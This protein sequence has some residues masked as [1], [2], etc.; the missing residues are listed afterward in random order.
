MPLSQL[1]FKG[2][3]LIF[4]SQ[5][6]K[7]IPFEGWD[8][9]L[10]EKI[11]F[12]DEKGEEA[13]LASVDSTCIHIASWIE[14]EILASRSTIIFSKNGKLDYY[15]RFGPIIIPFSNQLIESMNIKLQK[16]LVIQD[17][18]IQSV[19]RE[20]IESAIQLSLSNILTNSYLLIDGSLTS[21]WFYKAEPNLNQII[22][23]ALKN[24]NKIVGISKTSS[25][26]SYKETFKNLVF[27][28]NTPC[29]VELNS[30]DFKFN[31]DCKTI[32]CKFTSTGIPLRLDVVGDLETTIST[33]KRNDEFHW[34][35][36]ESLRL[37]HHL[38]VF[39]KYEVEC[40]KSLLTI[41]GAKEL[42]SFD[43]RGV[44]LGEEL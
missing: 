39:T 12:V 6:S 30:K 10:D 34:G 36:P 17:N 20:Y 37:A 27:S 11:K 7:L 14:G 33:I 16:G 22:K 44:T 21:S 43:P 31:K 42:P 32:I 4:Q 13:T 3:E 41:T 5:D 2:I 40:I 15:I 9:N 29:Y 38:S 25:L 1:S 24:N 18:V 28:K 26:I 19:I 8:F 23:N 35:Y